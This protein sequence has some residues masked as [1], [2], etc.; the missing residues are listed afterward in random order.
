MLIL[1]Y[2][3]LP[4]LLGSNTLEEFDNFSFKLKMYLGITMPTI[5]ESMERADGDFDFVFDHYPD[6]VKEQARSLMALLGS[7]CT[8]AAALWVRTQVDGGN[9][10]DGF[11]LWNELKR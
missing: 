9:K 3:R 11:K 1:R 7:R 8:D 6:D 2:R 4:T 10:F 5:V